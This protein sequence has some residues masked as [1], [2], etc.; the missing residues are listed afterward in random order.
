MTNSLDQF[1][2]Q[3]TESNHPDEFVSVA[4]PC[5]TDPDRAFVEMVGINLKKLRRDRAL[6]L[7]GLARLSGVSRAMLSQIE[8]GRSSPT[9]TV[10]YKI[11]AALNASLSEF[12]SRP[13][14]ERVSVL[15]K[16]QTRVYQ[17]TG[18]TVTSR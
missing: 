14:T 12:I 15:N 18:G 4:E 6:S 16:N 17:S 7:D 8:N 13:A 3:N 2:S 5:A 9:V 10:L 1:F 11:A